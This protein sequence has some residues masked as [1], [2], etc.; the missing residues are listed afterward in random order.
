MHGTIIPDRSRRVPSLRAALVQPRAFSLAPAGWLL[1]RLRAVGRSL[2]LIGW[3]LLAMPIQA[4]LLRLP[5]D[6][7]VRFARVFW[8]GFCRFIGVRR[9]LVGTPARGLGVGRLLVEDSIARAPL[10]GFDAIQFNLVFASNPARALYE[11][12]G[13]REIGRIPEAVDGEDAVIYWR[14]LEDVAT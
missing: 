4:V 2:G 7:K 11:S 13:W 14:S 8:A 6:A 1:R 9:R 12:L 5:G 10:A 3:T